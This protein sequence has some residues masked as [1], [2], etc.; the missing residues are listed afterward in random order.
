MSRTIKATTIAWLTSY[1]G[2]GDLAIDDEGRA[3]ENLCFSRNEMM[4]TGDDPWTRVGIAN[5]TV[6][7][8]DDTQMVENKVEALRAE[9]TAM[10]ATAQ[11][12]ATNIDRKINELL[13]I[14][15]TKPMPVQPAARKDDD[16]P[17]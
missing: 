8:V 2:P 16:F 4:G 5:I 14:D 12:R 1:R 10:L 7:L 13:A 6:E 15:W 3:V 17:F 11:A 9:K